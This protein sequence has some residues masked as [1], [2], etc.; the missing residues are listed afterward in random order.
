MQPEFEQILAEDLPE[1]DKLARAYLFILQ[2][3][4][5]YAQHE[6]ELQKAIGNHDELVKEQIKQSVLKYSSEIFAYCYFRVMG[7][8]LPNV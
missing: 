1:S 7:R 8:S 2:E 5:R 4:Q 6:I 3:Q